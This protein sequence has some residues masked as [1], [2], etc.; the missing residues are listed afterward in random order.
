MWPITGQMTELLFRNEVIEASRNRLT[1]TVIAAVPPSSRLYTRIVAGAALLLLALLLFGSYTMTADVRGIVAYDGGIARVYPRS[2][3]EV[4]AIHVKSG[5]HVEA[6][7][8]LVTLAIAQGQGGV[9]PQLAQI[10]NQDLELGRQVALVVDQSSSEIAALSQQR[11]GMIAAIASLE[12]QRTIASDQ[13]RLAESAARRAERLAK[14]GAGT[15]RQVED[16]RSALLSRRAAHEGLAEQLIVQ[17]NALQANEADRGRQKLEAQ[18]TQSVLLVQ[19]AVLAQQQLELSRTDKLVLTAPVSG[20]VGD[21]SVEIGQQAT[22]ERA[23]A[24]IIPSDSKLEIWLYAPSR[25][26][27]NAR[28]GQDVRLQFDAFPYQKFGSSRGVVT[29]IA[30]VPTEPSN[31]DTG[32][33][34]TEPVF[35]IRTQIVEFSPRAKIDIAAMRPGMTLSGKLVMERRSFWQILLG[36]IFEAVG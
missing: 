12:R 18:R 9:A 33:R 6:G 26:V 16:S 29:D 3:A 32:L 2:A 13:I 30:K 35:R 10:G 4:S 8:P 15:Q 25:A 21:I 17:R 7:Q 11:V 20:T 1:G 36:P 14:E 23:A 27:G 5:Q 22:P 19:R 24:S 34:I 31:V 28:P